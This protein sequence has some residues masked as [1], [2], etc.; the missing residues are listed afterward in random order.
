MIGML[1][2]LEEKVT[3]KNI[4][5][6]K[7]YIPYV[8]KSCLNIVKTIDEICRDHNIH[9]SLCGGSVIGAHLFEGFIP[10]DDDI[11]LMMS[12]KDYDLFIEFF[13]KEAPKKFHLLN[14]KTDNSAMVPTLFSRV[15]DLTTEI[16]EEIA[17][18]IRKGHVFVDITVIDNVSSKLMHKV[19]YLFGSYTYTKLYRHNGMTPGTGW[20]KILFNLF[21]VNVDEKNSLKAYTRFENFC[22]KKKDNKTEYCAELMSAAYSNFI[23][24]RAFFDEYI[25]INFENIKL[26]IVKKYMDYLHMRYGDREF[27]RDIPPN[28]RFN[29]HIIEFKINR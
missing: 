29:S 15:E 1:M 26:M 4:E 23:Y 12:R 14:Y 13:P 10:W 5:G 11:D 20:K 8:Q 21:A 18:Y 19:A 24:K 6:I 7:S 25:D 27:T 16:I 28:Q 2:C 9:Y 3:I 17:G 22:R